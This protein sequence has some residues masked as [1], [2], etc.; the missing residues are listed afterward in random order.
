[1][2]FFSHL[3]LTCLHS[4]S[5][6]VYHMK[7]FSKIISV[8]HPFS[9]MRRNQTCQH[10]VWWNPWSLSPKSFLPMSAKTTLKCFVTKG[11]FIFSL[12]D[13][14]ACFALE[15]TFCNMNI[16]LYFTLWY[17]CSATLCLTTWL[18]DSTASLWRDAYMRKVEYLRGWKCWRNFQFFKLAFLSSMYI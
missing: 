2:P 14:F 10:H 11:I 17:F 18:V 4:H 16:L 9:L 8:M 1:M 12:Y 6:S 5:S 15:T 3:Q 13:D 7:Q